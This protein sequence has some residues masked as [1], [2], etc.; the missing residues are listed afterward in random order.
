MS[1]STSN[2][3]F[4]GNIP[5]IYDASLGPVFF[6]PYA[7]DMAQRLVKLNPASV[8]ETA[9]GTGRV[10]AHLGNKLSIATKIIATDLNPGMLEVAKKKVTGKNIT[11]QQADAMDLPF[12]ENNFDTVV[13]QFGIMFYPDKLKGMQEAFRVLKKEGTFL[14]NVWDKVDY[15]PMAKTA[16]EIIMNFFEN[17]PPAFYNIPFGYN[18]TNEISSLLREAGFTNINFETVNKDAVA[19]SAK[20]MSDGLVEGNPIA[21]AI[22]ERNPDAVSILEEKVTREL[23]EKF[24][25]S[26]CKSVMQAIV[27]TAQ[28]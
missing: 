28:K 8:L 25:S 26:P 21:N 4:T 9:A 23:S 16:R 6:E 18:D 19:E 12:K 2:V 22:R 5:K 7:I 1:E 20:K 24:G 14:F 3:A 15:N 27:F 13:C 17:D 10:T 11:W